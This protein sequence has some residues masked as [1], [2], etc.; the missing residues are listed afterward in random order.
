MN[1]ITFE[2]I[3]SCYL[4]GSVALQGTKQN[5]KYQ[6]EITQ[7]SVP[8]DEMTDISKTSLHSIAKA[9][10]SIQNNTKYIYSMFELNQIMNIIT[11]EIKISCYLIWSVALQ[12]T[13]RNHTWKRSANLYYII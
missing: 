6:S 11:F 10:N 4:I 12:G 13:K 2:I 8:S 5:L 1:R 9:L 7:S 3:I